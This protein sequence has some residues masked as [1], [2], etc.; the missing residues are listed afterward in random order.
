MHTQELRFFTKIIMAKLPD[1]YLK[2]CINKWVFIVIVFFF[3][4]TLTNCPLQDHTYSNQEGLQ[5]FNVD[6]GIYE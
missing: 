5:F 6:L 2:T 1:H 4:G 3:W